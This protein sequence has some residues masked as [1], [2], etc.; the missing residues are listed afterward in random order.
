[1]ANEG[2]ILWS[3]KSGEKYSYWIYKIG[4]AFASSPGNYVFARETESKTYQPVYI[5]QTSD[6]SERFDNHHKMP[7]IKRNGATHIC[8]HKNSSGETARQDEESDLIE[9]YNPVCNG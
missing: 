4:Y 9:N 7:C 1:M 6:L 8:A 2:T 5:G 3:G